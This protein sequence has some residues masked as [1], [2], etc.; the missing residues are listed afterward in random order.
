MVALER[1][2]EKET[3]GFDR[4]SVPQQMPSQMVNDVNF[5]NKFI[6]TSED[7]INNKA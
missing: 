1:E 7:M 2:K 6:I 5:T 3:R 4:D